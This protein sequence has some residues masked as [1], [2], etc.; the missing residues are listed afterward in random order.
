MHNT[1]LY[2]KCH[3]A[4]TLTCTTSQ[5]QNTLYACPGTQGNSV[6]VGTASVVDPNCTRITVAF[7][8]YLASDPQPV[9][10]TPVPNG[11]GKIYVAGGASQVAKMYFSVYN[12]TDLGPILQFSTT[13]TRFYLDA[14]TSKV[15]DPS[16]ALFFNTDG[17]V[18]DG[19]VQY[20][21][22]DEVF[23]SSTTD[24]NNYGYL[25]ITCVSN[26]FLRCT[27]S[28]SHNTFYYCPN[29]TDGVDGHLPF[30]NNVVIGLANRPNCQAL[31]VQYVAF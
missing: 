28:D 27:T 23:L 12:D 9:P 20:L 17:A 13:P 8:P 15:S 26:G 3:S 18:S 31:T 30:G 5:N 2:L 22:E 21:A 11:Y 6:V 4:N 14:S 1:D 19:S 7:I 16:T 29:D 24:V 10:N 25:F